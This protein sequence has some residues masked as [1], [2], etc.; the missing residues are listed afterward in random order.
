MLP[1]IPAPSDAYLWV[2]RPLL[3]DA[4][5]QELR[6]MPFSAPV[7]GG[8][9]TASHVMCLQLIIIGNPIAR[10]ETR[11]HIRHPRPQRTVMRSLSLL[12]IGAVLLVVIGGMALRTPSASRGGMCP[13]S[14]PVANCSS[15]P[16]S[17]YSQCAACQRSVSC[18][19]NH[20]VCWVAVCDAET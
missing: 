17:F 16:P 9:T 20:Q 13:T 14:M 3:G 18:I 12:R 15:I 11:K 4:F 6:I 5:A 8:E 7:R 19:E 2:Q 10:T 1:D